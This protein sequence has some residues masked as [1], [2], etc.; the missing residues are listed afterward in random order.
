[1]D[2]RSLGGSGLMV[3]VLSFG[4][5]TFGGSN[6][7]FRAW[8]TTQVEEATRLVDIALE[9]GVTLFDTADVYSAG[10]SEDILGQ[11]I[12]GRRDRMLIATKAC[13]RSEPGP[14]GQGTS[15]YHLIRACEASLRRL[16]M[17]YIDLYQLHG[18]DAFTPVDETL[19]ALD[20]L[21]RS[22][23]VR[24]VGCSNYSGWHL[25][26]SLAVADRY[27]WP[28]FA[29]HQA[30]YSLAGREYE[31]ELMPLAI[32]QRVGTVVWSPLAGGRLTG[33]I[34]RGQ[35]PPKGSRSSVFAETAQSGNEEALYRTIDAMDEIAA[36]SGKTHSQIALNWLLQRPT[37]C[38]VIFGA[39]N[40]AQLR[41][42]LGAVGWNLTAEQVAR[43]D[44][45]SAVPMIYPYWHQRGFGRNPFPTS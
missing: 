35:P 17:D 14:N 5:A 20:D 45:A 42:N 18:F 4:T 10:L 41:E 32:D 22:G 7:F 8:G 38:T 25:M 37:V 12:G 28:R 33:K 9:A 40:E 30:Y 19:R 31:W 39:R 6:E 34:R 3:P 21:V 23:K 27:G 1:M 13:F 24:Y 43:L 26:K 36:A 15:R 16:R 11:A 2:Y 29:S 44:A